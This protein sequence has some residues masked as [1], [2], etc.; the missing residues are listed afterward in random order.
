[1]ASPRSGS[2]N[3][4]K[5]NVKRNNFVVIVIHERPRAVP[6]ALGK[7]RFKLWKKLIPR[8]PSAVE[9]IKTFFEMKKPDFTF[10]E[11]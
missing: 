1:L 2:A 11:T 3:V 4:V 6:G 10:G 5:L 7:K 8:P 9:K